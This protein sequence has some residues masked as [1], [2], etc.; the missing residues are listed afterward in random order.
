MNK[1]HNQSTKDKTSLRPMVGTSVGGI[2]H[3][4]RI[5]P[6]GHLPLVSTVLVHT[7][8]V[9]YRLLPELKHRNKKKRDR[10]LLGSSVNSGALRI[11][12]PGRE[13][14]TYLLV[15]V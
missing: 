7:C 2:K 1:N 3:G 12:L 9:L 10:L 14:D 4:T 8:T 5:Q 6:S 15:P 11:A 13:V